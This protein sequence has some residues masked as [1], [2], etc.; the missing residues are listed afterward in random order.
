MDLG[1]QVFVDPT[2]RDEFKREMEKWGVVRGAEYQVYR[3]DSSK[4]W[5]SVNARTVRDERGA[6]QYYE[7]F[8]QEITEPKRKNA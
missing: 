3:K 4:I 8:I 5:I 2:C 1:H 7:G 6:I